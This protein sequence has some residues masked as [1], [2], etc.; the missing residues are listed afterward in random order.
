MILIDELKQEIPELEAML[1]E[2]G[3]ALRPDELREKAAELEKKS[4][5]PGFWEDQEKAQKIMKE[6]KS[7]EDLVAEYDGLAA[8]LEDLRVM[9]D[10]AEEADDEETAEEARAEKDRLAQ[11]IESLKLKTLLNE[12]YDKNNAIIS[13]HAGSGGTEA[14]DWAAMLV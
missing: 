10:M 7:L 2:A 3:E 4:A 8:G 1:S 13:V 9:I 12:K 11:S 5:E 6:K 14:M